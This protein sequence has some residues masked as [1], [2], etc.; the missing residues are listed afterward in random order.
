MDLPAHKVDQ[1]RDIAIQLVRNAV[2]HGLKDAARRA[3]L[4]KN[5]A[6]QIEVNLTCEVTGEWQLSVRDDGAGLD[7]NCIR[8]K[9]LDSN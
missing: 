9:L 3:A 7:A 8:Q 5:A 6:G 4:G 2:V 1:M